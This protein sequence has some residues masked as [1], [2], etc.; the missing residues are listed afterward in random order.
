M[1]GFIN[2]KIEN[3]TDPSIRFIVKSTKDFE[4]AKIT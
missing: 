2:A 3:T 4:K 1:F